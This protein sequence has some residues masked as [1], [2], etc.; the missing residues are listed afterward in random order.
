VSEDQDQEQKTEDP[1]ERRL[2][3]LSKQGQIVYSKDLTGAAIFVAFVAI[4]WTQGERLA[5]AAAE[6]M[7]LTFSDLAHGDV[8]AVLN[9]GLFAFAR[10]TALPL[11]A[12][13][14]L[15]IVASI[16]QVGLPNE[17]SLM[18]KGGGSPLSRLQRLLTLGALK[19][20]GAQCIKLAIL[21][22]AFYFAFGQQT[23]AISQLAREPLGT[24]LGTIGSLTKRIALTT[25]AA[26]VVLGVFD[27]VLA[28]RRFMSSA[29][30]TKDE[31]K[32]EAK[33][34]AGSPQIK[35]RR[36]AMQ[37]ELAKRQTTKEV[38]AADVVVTNPTH[39]AVALRYK[40]QKMRAPRVVAKGVDHMAEQ[41]KAIARENGVPIVENVPLARA[42]HAQVKVGRDV[43]VELYRAVA[44]VLAFVYRARR[45]GR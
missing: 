32:R 11:A 27:Y 10:A 38:K 42:L 35:S 31:V 22:I 30:M 36:R 43:P 23:T 25:V 17:P 18:R 7:R 44:E 12:T 21:L 34:D 20:L 16:G 45:G 28:R 6:H 19:D 39:Y 8:R 41:I 3:E 5:G 26:F 9:D 14:A 13:F 24:G 40:S 1:T 29:R 33:E 2:S 15:A 4:V 37:R